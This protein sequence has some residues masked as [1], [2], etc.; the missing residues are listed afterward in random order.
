MKLS[1]RRGQSSVELA[2]VLPILLVVLVAA[3]QVGLVVLSKVSVT[4]TAREV[5]RVLAVD[6][7]A[8]PSATAAQVSLVDPDDLQVD[9]EWRPTA[10][11]RN[12]VVVTATHTVSPIV[13]LWAPNLLT[14][15]KV[16][17]LV[18]E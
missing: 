5:A 6:P 2:L 9:V 11:G 17:M 8:D 7:E 18:E 13:E 14:S 1:G 12:Y 16:M 4:H 15:A 10:S 3:V